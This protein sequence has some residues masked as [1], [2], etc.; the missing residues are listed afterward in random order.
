MD[1][2]PMAPVCGLDDQ[3]LIAQYDRYRRAGQGA[4]VLEHSSRRLAIELDPRVDRRLVEQLV[5]VERE[6][7]PFLGISWE[8]QS[9][10]LIV[11]VGQDDHESALAA[12]AFALDLEG[13]HGR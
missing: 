6:C 13:R 11:A 8:P 12:I 4:R 1:E 9:G 3:G 5:A 10:R 2:L 7:C